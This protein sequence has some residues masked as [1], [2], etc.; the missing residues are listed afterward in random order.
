M[1]KLSDAAMAAIK[2]A[3]ETT[4]HGKVV[5]TLNENCPDID[6]AVERRERFR[7]PEKGS[8]PIVQGRE[9]VR[10]EG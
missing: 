5:I 8:Q 4:P 7:K 2:H 1:N 9:R 6:I 3:I 10:R